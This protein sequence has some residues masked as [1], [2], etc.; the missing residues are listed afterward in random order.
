M[1]D[2]MPHL[3]LQNLLLPLMELLLPMS[4]DN[5]DT[6]WDSAIAAANSLNPTTVDEFRLAVRVSVSSIRANQC[7]AR[8]MADGI[9]PSLS[10]RT[11]QCGLAYARDADRA[12]R[13][14]EKL[15]AARLKAEQAP[16]EPIQAEKPSAPPEDMETPA[17]QPAA[18][19]T[20]A[21][22]QL[23]TYKLLKQLRRAEKEREKTAR[24]QAQPPS[25]TQ[26][27][28]PDVPMAA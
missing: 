3:L 25:G 21:P 27:P 10:I 4:N 15:Q 1:H 26:P 17:E 14:L 2:D 28:P 5:Q 11:A 23:P 22:P 7:A 18:R 9:T 20:A 12:E 19:P 24:K 6:A 16:P 13:Q 8:S